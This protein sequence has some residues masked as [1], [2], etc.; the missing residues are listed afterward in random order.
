MKVINDLL[1]M[2][3]NSVFLIDKD[4][5]LIDKCSL[6]NKREQKGNLKQ[7]LVS[8]KIFALQ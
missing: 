1:L 4:E 6:F 8:G 2:C 7:S 3:C 5:K